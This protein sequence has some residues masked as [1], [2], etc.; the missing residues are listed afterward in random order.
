MKKVGLYLKKNVFSHGQLYVAFSRV[1]DPKDITVFLDEDENQHGWINE[2]A[3][4]KNVVFSN[5]VDDEVEKFKKSDDYGIGPLEFTD[6]KFCFETI[7]FVDF[8]ITPTPH[9]NLILIL[10]RKIVR[11]MILNL[12]TLTIL[13][14]NL[15]VFQMKMKK[16]IMRD[17]VLLESLVQTQTLSPRFLP[18]EHPLQN[19]C[20][21]LI[22]I[23]LI[24]NLGSTQQT[25]KN[26]KR[27]IFDE[28]I[29]R[30]LNP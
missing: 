19:L 7:T 8:E 29:I 2:S 5:I 28:F 21:P 26:N 11:H 30:I 3:Y 23:L 13:K 25:T 20:L 16:I 17:I 15:K 4:T 6:G 18:P 27:K 9:P 14:I 1:S 10:T 22:G 24:G 12:V